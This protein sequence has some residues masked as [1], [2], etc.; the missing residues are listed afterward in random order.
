MIKKIILTQNNLIHKVHAI[1]LTEF[2]FALI[3][4]DWIIFLRN[5]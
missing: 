2:I 5:M 4:L 1:E 3:H